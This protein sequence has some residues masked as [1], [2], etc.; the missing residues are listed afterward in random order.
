MYSSGLGFEAVRQVLDEVRATE[1]VDDV[2]DAVLVGE[3][4]LRAECD[5]DGLL[6]RQR[7]RLVHRVGV[8]RLRAAEHGGERLDG[9]A[10]D[11]V[12]RLLG[13]ERRAAG[14]GVE[15]EHLRARA[16]RLEALLHDLRPDAP[17]R[18]ELRD[19]FEEVVVAGEEEAQAGQ[20]SRRHQDRQR[21][22]PATYAMPSASVNAISCAAV[23]PA[24]RMW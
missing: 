1:R 24:S 12:L 6:A 10:N 8:Q 2:A 17:R 18:P 5:L 7:Q 13:R 19:L 22:R 16:L 14:L 3:D 4:L 21:S 11:V 23:Q 9:R 20:R 15:A